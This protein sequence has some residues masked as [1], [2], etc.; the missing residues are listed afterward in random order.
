MFLSLQPPVSP[1]LYRVE[2]GVEAENVSV[3]KNWRH[4]MGPVQLS[5]PQDDGVQTHTL[6]HIVSVLPYSWM[7]THLCSLTHPGCGGWIKPKPVNV[8]R[9]NPPF[10]P[11]HF[12]PY[13]ASQIDCNLLLF[14][15]AAAVGWGGGGAWGTT[16]VHKHLVVA[17]HK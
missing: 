10:I 5:L 16:F 15:V 8:V 13:L 4:T 9:A 3:I 14:T 1:G 11:C 12:N 7:H 17:E 6:P 2:N